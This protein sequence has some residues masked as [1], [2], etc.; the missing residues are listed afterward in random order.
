[1]DKNNPTCRQNEGELVRLYVSVVSKF[2]KSSRYDQLLILKHVSSPSSDIL[3]SC[4]CTS[5]M[6]IQIFFS[7]VKIEKFI[8]SLYIYICF[9]MF[10][11]NLLIHDCGFSLEPP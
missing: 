5:T 2:V 3:K 6:Y 10:L 9:K 11:L 8:R 7:D 1:M 4:P